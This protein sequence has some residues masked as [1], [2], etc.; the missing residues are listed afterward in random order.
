MDFLPASA[1]FV[2]PADRDMLPSERRKFVLTHHSCVYGFARKT[3][4]PAMSLVGYIPTTTGELFISTMRDRGK[5]R[6]AARDGK[7]SICVIDEEQRGSYLQVYCDVVL[8]DD[9]TLAVDTMMALAGRQSAEPL[10]DDVRAFVAAMAEQEHR[11]VL[12]C[13]PYETFGQPP[14]S[15]RENEQGETIYHWISNR[16]PWDAED[17]P[18]Q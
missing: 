8:D 13:T 7:A 15:A 4:G 17:P 11:V 6:A 1:P 3:D 5:A 14:G 16:V 2:P 10:G 18:Q 12:R 9:P